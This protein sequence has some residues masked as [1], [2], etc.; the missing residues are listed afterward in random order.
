MKTEGREGLSRVYEF[1]A[2]SKA[3]FCEKSGELQH[4]YL[5]FLREKEKGTHD[6]K[7]PNLLGRS[8]HLVSG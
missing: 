8:S 6:P 5:L 2:K 1:S 4:I 3:S 7:T